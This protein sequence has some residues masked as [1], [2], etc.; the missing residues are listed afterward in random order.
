MTWE[1]HQGDCIEVMG[2]IEEASVDAVVCDPPYGI[3]FMG[4]AW[5]GAAI[6]AAMLERAAQAQPPHKDGSERTNPRMSR[7]EATGKYDLSLTTNRRYQGWCEAWAREAF[8]VL[9][10]GG[11]LLASCG[12]RTYHRLAVGVEDAGFEIRDSLSWLFGSGFPKSLDVSKAIDK[13]A[14]RKYVAAAIRLGLEIPSNNLHDW[15]KAEHCPSDAWW[16]RF[17]TVLPDEEWQRIEREVIDH[18]PRSPGWFTNGDGHDQSAPATP[19]AAQWQGWSTAL[20]PAHE[21]IIVA[22]KPLIGTVAENVLEHGTGGINVDGCRIEGVAWS[23]PGG[24]N[25]GRS[26]GIMGEAVDRGPSESNAAGRWPANVVLSHLEECE[27]VGVRVI[28]GDQRETGNGRRPGGFADVGAQNG[29]GE[30]NS[31]VYGDETI[32]EWNCAPGCPVA[33]LDAQSG[34]LKSGHLPAGTQR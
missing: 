21:P 30:P 4:A 2:E 13:L 19:E 9:K 18:N 27:P 10:P 25:A 3:G 33:E 16:E 28:K 20:K 5:D 26:G 31:P 1:I 24:L 6:E 23:R 8:R 15:T 32:N 34:V 29:D 7:A 17:K 12:T 22:R 11:H 14:R